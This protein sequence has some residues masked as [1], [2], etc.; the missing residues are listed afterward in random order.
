MRAWRSFA[1][2]TPASSPRAADHHSAKRSR[3]ALSTMSSP[4]CGGGGTTGALVA[5]PCY[6]NLHGEFGLASE[7]DTWEILVRAAESASGSAS[8]RSPRSP[9]SPRA[10]YDGGGEGGGGDGG[11]GD[12]GGGDG[13]GGDSTQARG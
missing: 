9:H 13:G 12:G 3:I 11:G 1:R 7:D 8:P 4:A 5:P 2:S 6:A 10:S